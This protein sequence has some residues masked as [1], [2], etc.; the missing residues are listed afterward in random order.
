MGPI[1]P[2]DHYYTGPIIRIWGVIMG[3]ILP[4]DHYYTGPIITIWGSKNDV[5][6]VGP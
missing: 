1:L 3:P 4:L 6:S 5:C 2:L